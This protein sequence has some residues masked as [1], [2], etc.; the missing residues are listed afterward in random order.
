MDLLV[1]C[2]VLC[3]Q[4]IFDSSDCRIAWSIRFG[5][6][7]G[8]VVYSGLSELYIEIL[9]LEDWSALY[10]Y[11]KVVV[12]IPRLLELLEYLQSHRRYMGIATDQHPCLQCRALSM[13]NRNHLRDEKQCRCQDL[14]MLPYLPTRTRCGL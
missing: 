2:V 11:Q 13:L 1:L 4:V 5:D 10:D 3:I 6:Q 8:N 12:N 14:R 7:Y 9:S